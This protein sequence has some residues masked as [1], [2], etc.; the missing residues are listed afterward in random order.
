MDMKIGFTGTRQGMT[1]PQRDAV[2]NIL[3]RYSGEFT[4][5][6][7][8]GSDRQVGLIADRLGY[9]VNIRPGDPAQFGFHKLEDAHWNRL[10]DPEPYMVRNQK[11]VDDGEDLIIATPSKGYEELR[12]GTWATVR[13][14]RKARR[15]L[16]IV[17]P[18]GSV[19]EEIG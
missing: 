11:I 16:M 8:N 15:R 14:A 7:C 12:S 13:M 17:F 6:G 10:Y 18:D 4:H 2:E 1:D 19:R 9:D 3:A 5:G